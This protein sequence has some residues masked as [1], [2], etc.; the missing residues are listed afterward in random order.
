MY[1]QYL[2]QKDFKKSMVNLKCILLH[3]ELQENHLLMVK[4]ILLKENK[5]FS[6]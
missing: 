5:N 4:E 3:E 1:L 6:F 2:T